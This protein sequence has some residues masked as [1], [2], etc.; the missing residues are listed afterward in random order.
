MSRELRLDQIGNS[1][2]VLKAAGA[3]SEASDSVG[4]QPLKHSRVV[5]AVRQVVVEGRE[6]VAL[7]GVLHLL[8]LLC[9]EFWHV[10][11]APIVRRGIHGETRSHRAVCAD[12]GVVL[13]GAAVP[14]G[15]MEL[16]VRIRRNARH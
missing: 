4:P 14:F 15:E 13:A 6:A 2:L 8:E 7:A 9:I 1:N 11:V 16:A 10:D 5:V 3:A 12:D